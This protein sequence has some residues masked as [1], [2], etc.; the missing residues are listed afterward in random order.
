M[1]PSEE[2]CKDCPF[3]TLWSGPYGGAAYPAC[4]HPASGPR[5]VNLLDEIDKCPKE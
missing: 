5:S 1:T 3:F 2:K 4:N